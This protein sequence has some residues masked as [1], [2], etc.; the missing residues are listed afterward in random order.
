MCVQ[1]TYSSNQRVVVLDRFGLTGSGT[2]RLV[3]CAMD[4]LHCNRVRKARSGLAVHDAP[5]RLGQEHATHVAVPC[6][7]VVAVELVD[8]DLGILDRGHGAWA[9]NLNKVVLGSCTWKLVLDTAEAWSE[10]REGT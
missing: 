6:G 7:V 4:R 3:Q 2:S 10:A 5:H 9:H 1:S 8:G